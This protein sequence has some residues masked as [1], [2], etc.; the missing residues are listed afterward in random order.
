MLK[1]ERPGPGQLRHKEF[2]SKV[3]QVTARVRLLLDGEWY[4]ELP[5]TV[6]YSSQEA[7]SSAERDGGEE[8][9]PI[10]RRCSLGGGGAGQAPTFT[11]AGSSP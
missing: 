1:A 5:A 6:T 7:A 3:E 10:E 8:S 9:Q 4:P 11:K 2:A